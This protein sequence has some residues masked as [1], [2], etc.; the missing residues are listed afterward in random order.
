MFSHSLIGP[1]KRQPAEW[2]LRHSSSSKS[3]GPERL[4][5][6]PPRRQN[7]QRARF[8]PGRGRLRAP[9]A[10]AAGRARGRLGTGASLRSARARARAGR[11]WRCTPPAD[12]SRTAE[13]KRMIRSGCL[14]VHSDF[15]RIPLQDS[16]YSTFRFRQQ[17]L[18]QL[19]VTYARGN[20]PEN[21]ATTQNCV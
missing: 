4:E 2:S 19:K 16:W 20:S 11:G 1:E 18:E 10:P 6:Y 17:I 15:P 8:A 9:L 12:P 5:S 21:L 13:E 14:D 3:G 7:P